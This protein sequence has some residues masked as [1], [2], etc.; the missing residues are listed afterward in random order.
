[1]VVLNLYDNTFRHDVCSVAG[2]T[3][4]HIQ[5]VRDQHPWDGITLFVDGCT[6]P[7]TV[8]AVDSPI[9]IGWL[10]EPPCL[11]PEDYEQ[12]DWDGLDFVLTYAERFAGWPKAVFAPYAGAWIP[13]ELWGMHRKTKLCSMLIGSKKSTE[14]H[15]I[16]HEVADLVEQFSFVHFYGVRGTPTTYGWQT[17]MQVLKDYAFTIVTEACYDLGLFTTWLLDCLA[18]GTIPV[19]WGCPNIGDFFHADGVLS[20]ETAQQA[21]EIVSK[22]SFGLYEQMKGV[23]R[24]NL[25][26]VEQ[27]E[28]TE[29]WIYHNV[30]RKRGLA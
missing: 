5:Y 13:N 21:Q 8:R 2:K 3:P 27:Y 22:L 30:L 14:G 1:M 19:Y 12:V 9:K 23:A 17:K 6:K 20:F 11:H 24:L 26:L 16:R 29:D 25:P 28:V 15:I 18:M 7:G 10:H 4:K